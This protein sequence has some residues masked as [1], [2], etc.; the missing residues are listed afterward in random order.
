VDAYCAY[1]ATSRA[2]RI[3]CPTLVTSGGQ[4]DVITGPRFAHEVQRAIPNSTLHLFEHTSHNFWVESF[5]EWWSVTRD[6]L[7]AHGDD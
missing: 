5:D 4:Q 2:G 6:F 7:G 3:R 1:D